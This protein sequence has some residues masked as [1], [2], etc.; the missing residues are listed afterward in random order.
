MMCISYFVKLRIHSLVH[1]SVSTFLGPTEVQVYLQVENDLF[2]ARLSALKVS[3]TFV[4]FVQPP[5][6]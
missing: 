4:D 1:F 3:E 2:R 5:I 6:P